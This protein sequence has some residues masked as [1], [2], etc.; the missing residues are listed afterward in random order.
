MEAFK[1]N[2]AQGYTLQHKENQIQYKIGA[3]KQTKKKM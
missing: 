3:L 2:L 1:F